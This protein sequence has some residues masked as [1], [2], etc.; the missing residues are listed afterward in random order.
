MDIFIEFAWLY[1]Q[2]YGM[3]EE[4][5]WETVVGMGTD[6]TKV[7]KGVAN[8]MENRKRKA[9]VDMPTVLGKR[10][11]TITTCEFSIH[12][13]DKENIHG[14]HEVRPDQEDRVT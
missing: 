11:N 8:G 2:T 7:T 4:F 13:K 10:E 6:G 9:K 5:G 1:H 12:I 3:I 14:K